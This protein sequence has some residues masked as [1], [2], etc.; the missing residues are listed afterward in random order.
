MGGTGRELFYRE[1]GPNNTTRMMVVDVTLEDT[2]AA[3]IP[4]PLFEIR[5]SDYPAGASPLRAYDVTRDGRRFLMT[6]EDEDSAEPPITHVVIV[7]HWLEELRRMSPAK[8]LHSTPRHGRN[9][10]SGALV[11]CPLKQQSPRKFGR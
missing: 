5:S 8:L 7:Q 10:Y 2:F 3:G 9:T 6:Q 1:Q 4:R 11:F